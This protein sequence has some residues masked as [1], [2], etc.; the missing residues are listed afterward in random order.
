M[1]WL[2]RV[3]TGAKIPKHA[4]S[5][6]GVDVAPPQPNS[7]NQCTGFRFVQNATMA[8]IRAA[9]D[10]ALTPDCSCIAMRRPEIDI[11]FPWRRTDGDH[12]GLRRRGR[13][14]H[15]EGRRRD[16][17]QAD[18]LNSTPI[19]DSPLEF[20]L[21]IW[22]SRSTEFAVLI[23]A[24]R[25]P[26]H[27]DIRSIVLRHQTA[28]SRLVADGTV[29]RSALSRFL[30]CRRDLSLILWDVDGDECSGRARP[31]RARRRRLDGP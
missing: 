15:L 1:I 10:R 4:A 27:T 7:S 26:T 21:D 31:T 5:D 11:E 3:L 23:D 28:L 17:L 2:S 20:N 9:A 22:H 8:R 12:I 29:K 30:W 16:G 13:L 6:L 14:P 18:T 24:N 25:L 19:P